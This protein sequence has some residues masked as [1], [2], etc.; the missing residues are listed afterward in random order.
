[1]VFDTETTG[2][3]PSAGDEILSIAGVR[4]VNGRILT[5]E[6]FER[7]VDPRRP[8]PRES[9]RYHGIT[10]EMVRDKPPIQ[11]VLPQFRAFVGDAV[12]VAHNAAFDLKFITL[13]EAECGVKF[14]MPVLDT[15]LLSA[16]V[17]DHSPRHSLD[18]VAQRFGISISSRHTAA[19]DTLITAGI[20]LK[21]IDVLEARGVHTLDQ[22]IEVS[23]TIVEVRKQQMSF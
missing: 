16:F 21:M 22:A 13:K 14:D 3:E 20:F 7:V 5:G 11:V 23:Q 9:I 1:V 12:L 8:I 17:H 4:I 10:E 18:A 19:G 15:L 6:L 2:L